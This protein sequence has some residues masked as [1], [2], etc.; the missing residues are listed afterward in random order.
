MLALLYVNI[1][2]QNINIEKIFH[3]KEVPE[4]GEG[5]IAEFA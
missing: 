1:G 3:R 2:K 5:V 4:G